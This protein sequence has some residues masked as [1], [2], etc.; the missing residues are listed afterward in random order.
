MIYNHECGAWYALWRR[1]SIR[2]KYN[3]AY[4]YSQELC[5]N[6]IPYIE[7]DR[8]WYTVVG[9]GEMTNHSV[10]FIH[11]NSYPEKYNWLKDYDDLLL[12]C[13]L[14]Q[15]A[16]RL[17]PLG[18]P[19]VV[20]PLSVDVEYVKQFRVKKKTKNLAYVGRPNRL[21]E[22]DCIEFVPGIPYIYGLPRAKFLTEMAK[23]KKVYASERAA[24]E[25]KI[26][27]CEVIPYVKQ[28]LDYD[29]E[30]RDNSEII[31]PLQEA[32]DKIDKGVAYEN[33][34]REEAQQHS[35]GAP[36]T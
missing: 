29:F 30:V 23:Y 24:I 12:V 34:S 35:E 16:E 21:K 19:T 27:G 18:H 9:K 1:L 36:E 15:T 26:L 13:S 17:K 33:S 20:I 6:V 3:G 31:K 22:Y 5:E 32:I 10:V 25:A 28:F 4:F 8:D 2:N 7:T 11:Q 14:P